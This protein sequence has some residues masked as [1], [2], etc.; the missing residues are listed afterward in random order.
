MSTRVLPTIGGGVEERLTRALAMRWPWIGASGALLI[1]ASAQAGFDDR[2]LTSIAI[3]VPVAFAVRFPRTAAV[4]ATAAALGWFFPQ[5]YPIP[6][7]AG[8]GLMVVYGVAAYRLR[9]VDIGVVGALFLV[10]AV[11]P[12][13]GSDAGA[14]TYLLLAVVAGALGFGRLLRSRSAIISEHEA[15]AVAH[16]SA[17]REHLLLTD[18]TA[19]ARELHDVVAHHISHI[20]IQAETARYTTPDLPE[21]AATRLAAIG[22]SARTALTEMRTILRVIRSPASQPE[23][24]GRG[25]PE[26]T[27][28]PR[29]GLGQL[30]ALVEAARGHG[31]PVAVTVG[32]PAAPIPADIDLVAYRV[33][34]ES[35]TNARR[36]APGAEVDVAVDRA[37]G[38]LRLTIHNGS[39]GPV[40]STDGTG[41][42]LVGMRERVEA[43]G[44]TL[45]HGPVPDGGF[46]VVAELPLRQDR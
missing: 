45:R 17:L 10:N 39:R 42:G 29:P 7:A 36:H 26:S 2:F 15:L 28:A 31:T 11:S 27:L 32:G 13:N 5:G 24:T 43:V 20:A 22:E 1:A 37:P 23:G 9:A 41:L 12:F 6:V 4:V 16:M 18:R 3:V 46:T 35:L 14:A 21:L 34:Q 33:I 8:A 40:G 19:I 38:L 44:G 30:D 25:Q